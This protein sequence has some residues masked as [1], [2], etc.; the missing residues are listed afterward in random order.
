MNPLA[1]RPP[2][3]RPEGLSASAIVTRLSGSLAFSGIIPCNSGYS[4]VHSDACDTRDSLPCEYARNIV[5]VFASA[6]I[7]GVSTRVFGLYA[8]IL[9]ARVL[10]VSQRTTLRGAGARLTSGAAPGS[11]I[12]AVLARAQ[13]ESS[14]R[15]TLPTSACSGASPSI[16]APPS[17]TTRT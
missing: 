12:A 8:L 16:T 5:E 11:A 2:I 4:D 14:T 9:S 10:S 3:Q 7:V 13:P 15:A 17:G 6:E 1:E